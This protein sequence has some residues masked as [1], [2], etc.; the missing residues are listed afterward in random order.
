MSPTVHSVGPRFIV[1]TSFYTFV[2]ARVLN[3]EVSL[4]LGGVCQCLEAFLVFC[5]HWGGATH[6][7]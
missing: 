5:P 2:Y 1:I 3:R 7:R 6:I 4:F